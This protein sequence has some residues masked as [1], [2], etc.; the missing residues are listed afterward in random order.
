MGK[1]KGESH[2]ELFQGLCNNQIFPLNVLQFSRK[3]HDSESIDFLKRNLNV[4]WCSIYVESPIVGNTTS[5]IN[6]NLPAKE[7]LKEF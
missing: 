2:Q 7:K 1:T 6:P 5:Q 3:I 4:Q